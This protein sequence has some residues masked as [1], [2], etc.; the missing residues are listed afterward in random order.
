V[1]EALKETPR[2]L[3]IVLA[4]PTYKVV[5]TLG[6]MAILQLSSAG[7]M[8]L[9]VSRYVHWLHEDKKYQRKINIKKSERK[10]CQPM[11][12]K[13]TPSRPT[14]KTISILFLEGC[15]LIN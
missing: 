7:C 8:S 6:E 5:E 15:N 13:K 1:L 9:L 2:L 4:T 10:S 14:A 11:G 3:E 12:N